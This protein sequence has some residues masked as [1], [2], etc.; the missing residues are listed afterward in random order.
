M[1][2]E[3]EWKTAQMLDP[4]VSHVGDVDGLPYSQLW[5][6]PAL[7]VWQLEEIISEWKTLFLSLCKHIFQIHKTMI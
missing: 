6:G 5:Y 3:K 4:C 1:H 2:S 7:A